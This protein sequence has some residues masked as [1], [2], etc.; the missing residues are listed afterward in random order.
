MFAETMDDADASPYL[1]VTWNTFRDSR[2]SM[3][4]LMLKIRP[5]GFDPA[6]KRPK[7]NLSLR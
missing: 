1:G 4:R 7:L 5:T 6:G 2:H 3:S